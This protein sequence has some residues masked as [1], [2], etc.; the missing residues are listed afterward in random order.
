MPLF[1]PTPPLVSTSPVFLLPTFSLEPPPSVFTSLFPLP[2]STPDCLVA[3]EKSRDIGLKSRISKNTVQ[4]IKT[5][6]ADTTALIDAIKSGN[7]KCAALRAWFKM[8]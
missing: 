5:A 6:A 3:R 7:K 2:V 4:E 1:A 8:A